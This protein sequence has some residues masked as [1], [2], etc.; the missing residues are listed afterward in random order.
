M[1]K[2]KE[3]VDVAE[4]ICKMEERMSVLEGK[5]DILISKCVPAP[6]APKPVSQ[7]INQPVSTQNHGSGNQSNNHGGKI[8]FKAVCADCKKECE[9][10]FKPRGERPVYCKECFSKRKGGN[11]NKG[12]IFHNGRDIAS[13]QPIPEAKPENTEKKVPIAKKVSVPKKKPAPKR[14]KA[15]K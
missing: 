3:K 13:V 14:R 2:R 4:L 15:G 8:M 10:P 1:K 7:P 6:A 11:Q 5:I 9:V 12:V